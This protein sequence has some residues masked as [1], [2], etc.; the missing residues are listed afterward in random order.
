[1]WTFDDGAQLEVARGVRTIARLGLDPAPLDASRPED[2]EWLRAC[3]WPGD[4]DRAARLEPALAAFVAARAR[5]DAPVLVPV[6]AARNVPA[7]LDALSGREPDVLVLAY[8]TAAARPARSDD[9]RAEYEA[10]HARLARGTAAGPR[11]L[12]GAR[13][14][15]GPVARPRPPRNPAHARTSTAAPS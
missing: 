11:A 5:P 3:V 6:S 13:A 15:R 10:G 7:R 12:G 8:Q 4:A 14:A 1:M 9:E 2:A